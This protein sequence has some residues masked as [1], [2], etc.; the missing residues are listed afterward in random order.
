MRLTDKELKKII[1]QEIKAMQINESNL[2]VTGI[3]RAIDSIF[4]TKQW[5]SDVDGA[6]QKLVHTIANHFQ[7]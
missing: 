4:G 2:N 1:L 3:A 5:P 6:F 7:E